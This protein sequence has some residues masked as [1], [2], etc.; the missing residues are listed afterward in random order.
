MY[1]LTL[2]ALNYMQCADPRADSLHHGRIRREYWWGWRVGLGG[3][4]NPEG[5]SIHGLVDTYLCRKTKHNGT[6]LQRYT[7][8]VL[9]YRDLH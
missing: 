6:V 5:T 4:V 2:V 9:M 7:D 8:T 1:L 3:S